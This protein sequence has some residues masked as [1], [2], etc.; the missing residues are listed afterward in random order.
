MGVIGRALGSMPL[1]AYGTLMFAPVIRSVIGRVP[2]C[3]PAAINGYRR[4]EVIGE[5][6]PGLVKESGGGKVDGILYSNI[7][8]LEWERLTAF[9]DDFYQLEQLSVIC[10]DGERLALA[11]VVPPSR[12]SILSGKPWDADFFRAQYLPR[13][14]P[15]ASGSRAD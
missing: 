2:E 11:Y 6:F 5:L 3:C 10:P 8:E 4:L 15:N 12:R 7:R 14:V 1:F 13:F 9:E